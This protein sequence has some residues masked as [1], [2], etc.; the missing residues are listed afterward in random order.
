VPRTPYLVDPLVSAQIPQ[1]YL[2]SPTSADYVIINGETFTGTTATALANAINA[3]TAAIGVE[4]SIGTSLVTLTQV[5]PSKPVVWKS[6]R[7]SKFVLTPSAPV[8]TQWVDDYNGWLEY[9]V[10]EATRLCKVKEA[11]DVSIE[12]VD[13]AAIVERISR[14]AANRNAGEPPT[15]SDVVGT[16]YM[17]GRTPFSSSGL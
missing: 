10:L 7:P 15:V 3:R 9:A 17:G 2:S 1:I 8:W 16:D 4:A 12:M 6:Y 5:D 13:K 11:T 14:A